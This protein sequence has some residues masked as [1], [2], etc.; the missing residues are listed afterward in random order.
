MSVRERER[1]RERDETLCWEE[2]ERE[3][4]RENMR[5][6]MSAC[7]GRLGLLIFIDRGMR[8]E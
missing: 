7:V 1:E 6:E 4:E 2:R 3:R 8:R 5:N